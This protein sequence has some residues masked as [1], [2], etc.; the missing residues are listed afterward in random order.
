[1]SPGTETTKMITNLVVTSCE[2]ISREHLS[3]LTLM[4]MTQILKWFG[5]LSRR[6][7]IYAPRLKCL[8]EARPNVDISTSTF[9]ILRATSYIALS[10]AW[11]QNVLLFV[12]CS[13]GKSGLSAADTRHWRFRLRKCQLHRCKLT[14]W[15]C[16]LSLL[17]LSF[18]ALIN[19][20]NKHSEDRKPPPV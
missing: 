5:C 12:A 18:C 2:N 6:G 14:R 9:S 13:R 8:H 15:T 4:I 19:N 1:M 10:P 11:A 16:I 7:K 20:N 3:I 17:T